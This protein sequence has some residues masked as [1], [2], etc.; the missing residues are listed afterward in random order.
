MRKTVV[1]GRMRLGIFCEMTGVGD[2]IPVDFLPVPAWSWPPSV[3]WMHPLCVCIREY[4]AEDGVVMAEYFWYPAF[5]YILRCGV[6]AHVWRGWCGYWLGGCLE[7]GVH[8]RGAVFDALSHRYEFLYCAGRACCT[9]LFH[10]LENGSIPIILRIYLA[11]MYSCAM[12]GL[13]S[14]IICVQILSWC[15]K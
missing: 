14:V 6:G 2:G 13:W 15:E 9:M 10:V 8:C 12:R 11:V 5:F 3:C 4:T 7:W 1:P